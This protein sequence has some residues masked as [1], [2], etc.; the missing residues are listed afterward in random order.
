M[1]KMRAAAW[2]AIAVCCVAPAGFAGISP[3]GDSGAARC[4]AANSNA[5]IVWTA[6]SSGAI[7]S[8]RVYFRTANAK[9]EHFVEMR[10][11][12]GTPYSAILPKPAAGAAAIEYRIAAAGP[13]GVY[14]TRSAG[15]LNVSKGCAPDVLN[16]DDS[17]QASTIVV[18][19]TAEGPVVP[20]GFRCEG[21]VGEI[22]R[23]GELRSY[24]AC[25]EMA[26]AS[27]SASFSEQGLG[28]SGT[29]TAAGTTASQTSTGTST[30]TRTS[31][32]QAESYGLAVGPLHHRTPRREPQPAQPPQPRLQE[33]VSPSRP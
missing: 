29:R 16:A 32:P 15:R 18:G 3:Q 33:P 30:S 7:Q 1:P 20:I 28:R 21:I 9:A 19:I 13:N 6:P 31:T 4:L 23:D 5:K 26:I 8:V 11:A 24:S 2:F 25:S 12:R 17:M 14:A 22:T 10:R 27:M